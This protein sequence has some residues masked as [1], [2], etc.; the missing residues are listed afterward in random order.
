[1]FSHWKRI[2]L[3]IPKN[4]QTILRWLILAG[5]TKSSIS[6]APFQARAV[7][8]IYPNRH[9]CKSRLECIVWHPH[10]VIRA[11]AIPVHFLLSN[12]ARRWHGD[13]LKSMR[14][15]MEEKNMRHSFSR[16]AQQLSWSEI[17]IEL[18]SLQSMS[19]EKMCWKIYESQME[20]IAR[21]NATKHLSLAPI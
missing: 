4:G 10:L 1:M 20:K 21:K 9:K 11:N 19:E 12:H 2:V 13:G 8:S 3:A 7:N 16:A 17:S 5:E 14:R 6:A 18:H 15:R